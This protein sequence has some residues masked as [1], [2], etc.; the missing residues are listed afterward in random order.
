MVT[1]TLKGKVGSK[2]NSLFIS[3]GRIF[4]DDRFDKWK[5]FAI[6]EIRKNTDLKEI[7]F[8]KPI[9]IEVTFHCD[10]R[11]D[12]DN[13]LSSIFDLLQDTKVIQNDRLIREVHIR[14]I[15]T[16]PDDSYTVISLEELN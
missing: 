3:K 10:D 13:M 5:K 14:R 9:A 7:Y 4:H 2:K 6:E 8:V 11:S 12:T 15:K 1:F 16:K